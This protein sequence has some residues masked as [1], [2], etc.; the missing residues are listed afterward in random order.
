MKRLL[1]WAMVIALL[2]AG[3]AYANLRAS[4]QLPSPGTLPGFVLPT[5]SI[6]EQS[7][8]IALVPHMGLWASWAVEPI[9]R[10]QGEFPADIALAILTDQSAITAGMSSSWSSPNFASP[11]DFR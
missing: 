7:Q 4:P 10:N 5:G 6:F 9:H 11:L 3:S 8:H 2:I 1:I